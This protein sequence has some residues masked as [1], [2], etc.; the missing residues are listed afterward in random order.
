[1][2]GGEINAE[3]HG[4]AIDYV[5][6]RDDELVIRLKNNKELIV[7]WEAGEPKLKRVD[8]RIVLPTKL[9]Q[10]KTGL[11]VYHGTQS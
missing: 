4:Q 1:M 10:A 2:A 7:V 8:V 6:Y 3:C 5:Y 11:G 9:I